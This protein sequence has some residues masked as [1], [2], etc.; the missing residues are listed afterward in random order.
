VAEAASEPFGGALV[1]LSDDP[2]IDHHVMVVGLSIDLDDPES[3]QLGLHHPQ[4]T[5]ITPAAPR[6][7]AT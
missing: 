3:K 5:L 7:C 2:T 1:S 4:A 6:R